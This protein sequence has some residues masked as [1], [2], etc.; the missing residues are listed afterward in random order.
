MRDHNV[1]NLE[2]GNSSSASEDQDPKSPVHPSDGCRPFGS[3]P[4]EGSQPDSSGTASSGQDREVSRSWLDE[5]DFDVYVE[6]NKRL[7]PL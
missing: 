4:L 7:T 5:R 2:S 1:T 6:R 3:Q